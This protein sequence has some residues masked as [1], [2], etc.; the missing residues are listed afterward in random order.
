MRT[1]ILT[2]DC[3]SC[4]KLIIN[5]DNEFECRWGNSK[6]SKVLKPHKGKRPYF[7]RLKR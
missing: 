4:P 2:P 6:M 5:D 1:K 7:C 3:P